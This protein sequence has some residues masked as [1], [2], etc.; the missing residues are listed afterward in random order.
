MIINEYNRAL[1]KAYALMKNE[2]PLG[3]IDCGTVC[4]ARCCGGDDKTGMWLFPH[5]AEFVKQSSLTVK[6]TEANFGCP[7]AVCS[8]A[9]KRDERPLACRFFPLFPILIEENGHETV[10]V[11]FDPRASVCPLS[12]E[13]VRLSRTFVRAVRRAGKCLAADEE[14]NAY[15]KKISNELLELAELAAKLK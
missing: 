2:T 6:N 12:A 14:I 7:A 5:E 3:D 11:I 8:G 9:C 10:K 4:G 15:M 13:G 1:A